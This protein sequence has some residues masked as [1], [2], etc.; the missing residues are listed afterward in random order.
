MG[1]VSTL[2]NNV[3]NLIKNVKENLISIQQLDN[4][5][6]VK[7][8]HEFSQNLLDSS[9]K[10][11]KENEIDIQN[12]LND[13][14]LN[15]NHTDPLVD[16]LKL[17]PDRIKSMSTSIIQIADNIEDPVGEVID[18]WVTDAGLKIKKVRVPMGIIGVIYEARPNVTVDIIALSLKTSNGVVLK[19]GSDAE[20]TN[21]ILFDIA[22]ESIIKAGYKNV[23]S[24]IALLDNNKDST[25]NMLKLDK[26]I[27]LIIPRGGEG[28]KKFVLENTK[29]PVLS[30]GGGNCSV[31]IAQS[32][33]ISMSKDI[34]INAKTQRPTV[35][36]ALEHVFVHVDNKTKI[37]SIITALE[38]KGCKIHV[39][40]TPYE[41][42]NKNLKIRESLYNEFLDL[43]LTICFVESLNECISVINEIS[44]HHSD[45]IVTNDENEA[46]A[47]LANID[48]AC[49]YHNCSTRFTDGFEF[50]FGAEVGISTQK[51]HAR[52]PIGT[53]DI[54][55]YK[56]IISGSGTIRK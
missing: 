49:V 31:Y 15:K 51:L 10:I 50:G 56:Y 13:K 25:K 12:Y 20:L 3:L 48:S 54:C 24:C 11:L 41:E 2:N 32:A 33:D 7:I 38:N 1:K 47:F 8:L 6:K 35:C 18:S 44:T 5:Q 21:K 36:N 22:I 43:E 45:G 17:T 40:D 39:Y 29:I 34:I 23:S 52:G 28:L 27:D 53:K 16:R 19:G 9:K 55:T 37:D 26:Y 4:L 14:N 42:N 46:E 30:S